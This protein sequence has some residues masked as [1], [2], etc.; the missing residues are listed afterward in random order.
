MNGDPEDDRGDPLLAE[1]GDCDKQAATDEIA[2]LSTDS[3]LPTK[4]GPLGGGCGRP[5]WGFSGTIGLRDEGGG[6]GGRGRLRTYSYTLVLSSSSR[7]TRVG[8]SMATATELKHTSS[9]K[10]KHLHRT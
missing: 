3:V 4:L 5:D 1:A 9:T 7:L 10:Q 2:A 6:G 8:E